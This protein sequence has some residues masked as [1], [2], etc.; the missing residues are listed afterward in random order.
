MLVYEELRVGTTASSDLSM[1]LFKMLTTDLIVMRR[2]WWGN[3]VERLEL[4]PLYPTEH[5]PL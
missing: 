5:R 4:A 3:N 2:I 1:T